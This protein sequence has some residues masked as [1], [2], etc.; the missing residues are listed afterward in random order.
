MIK[1][2]I[3]LIAFPFCLFCQPTIE[4]ANSL[5]KTKEYK[6]AITEFNE[7]I[8]TS[9]SSYELYMNR[10]DCFF[11]LENFE[12]AIKDYSLVI[13]LNK[14]FLKAYEKRSGAYFYVKEFEKAI[15]DFSKLIELNKG[16]LGLYYFMR[17]LCKTLIV[18]EDVDGAC[19][20][21]KKAVSLG[22]KTNG[23][24]GLNKYCNTTGLE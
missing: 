6:K 9:Q 11:A 16:D 17:G 24:T 5:V 13:D 7:L 14:D 20:D 2:I 18:K 23:M 12:D 4:S 22:Y 10:G 1:S 19:S 21:I 3:I 8:K 15:N